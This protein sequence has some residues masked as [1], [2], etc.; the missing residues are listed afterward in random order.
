MT[1][2]SSRFFRILMVSSFAIAVPTLIHAQNK[3]HVL[4]GQ[5]LDSTNKPIENAAVKIN[6][7][8]AV[9]NEQG[10]FT[11]KN[12]NEGNYQLAIS[13]LGYKKIEKPII[14]TSQDTSYITLS[15]TSAAANLENL[16]VTSYSNKGYTSSVYA[17]GSRFPLPFTQVPNSV[18]TITRQMMNDLNMFTLT[19]ALAQATGVTAINYGDGS[20]YFQSRGFPLDIQ[21]DGLPSVGGV[22][23][24]PQ[25]DLAM[26][27]NI[28]LLKGPAGILQGSSSAAGV[29]SMNRK[30]PLDSMAIA[31]AISYGSWRNFRGNIDFT[32][33]LDKAGKLKSRFVVSGDNRHYFIDQQRSNHIMAYGILQYD[34]TKNTS[35]TLSGTYE[36]DVMGPLDYG[37]G[38]KDNGLALDAPRSSFFGTP[39]SK[40]KNKMG[41]VYFDVKQKLSNSWQAKVA[42]DYRTNS[43][44][45]IYGYLVGPISAKNLTA[46]YASQSQWYKLS[47]LTVD[48]N[49]NGHFRLFGRD[50]LAAFGF[51]YSNNDR[52]NLSGFKNYAPVDIFNFTIPQE[53]VPYTYGEKDNVYQYGLYGQTRLALLDRLSL[54]LGGRMSWF[55]SKSRTTIPT[56]QAWEDGAKAN[57][58]FTPYAGL[59]Y[60]LTSQTSVYVNYSNVFTPQNVASK[61]GQIAPEKGNQ[62][63]AGLKGSFFNNNLNASVAGFLIYDENRAVADPTNVRFY[64]ANGKVRSRGIETEVSGRITKGW[65]IMT[66][67]TF[68]ETKYLRDPNNIGKIFSAEEPKHTFKIWT[69][70]TIQDGPLRNV[71]FGAGGRVM[72]DANRGY[73]VQKGYAVWNTQVGYNFLKKW[74]ATLNFNNML[75]KYYYARIPSVF[76]GVVGD[77]RNF[78]LTLR[79]NF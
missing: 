29:V 41:E 13:A 44:T 31:G 79:K 35:F 12:L 52:N 14:V 71:V 17:I 64:V 59:V 25:F 26:Y 33:P 39:W 50:Q 65:N 1:K 5:L 19:D 72:S 30:A 47:W 61:S 4:V 51:N 63:E 36:K 18:S 76:Y 7:T 40:V 75:N 10:Y 55:R 34:A 11:L 66:G 57:S 27:D 67:Y 62:Y 43:D 9:S 37:A 6:N 56:L 28:Q 42:V 2:L 73:A 74:S 24:I 32:T 53:T 38:I 69:S 46:K 3:K 8:H 60:D 20:A 48:A 58:Q 45:A 54:S 22:Q 23:Y 68:L 78:M 15:L 16:T 77:P 21:Y 70:Y 49:V